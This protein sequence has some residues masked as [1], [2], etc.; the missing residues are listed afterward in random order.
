MDNRSAA[1]VYRRSS[2]ENA[3]PAKIVRL[4]FEGALRFL[5]RARAEDPDDPCSDFLHFVGR[6][7]AI[8]SE[9]R[10]AIDTE[11]DDDLTRN[12][13]RL[14]LFCES[15]LGRAGIERA[16]EPL[17]GVRRVLEILLVAWREVEVGARRVA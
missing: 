8:V 5:D 14:Y 12:L 16:A 7:D 6:V 11:I 13:E 10:L 3:P 1:D 15:E 17:V 2:I 9:L 4:L